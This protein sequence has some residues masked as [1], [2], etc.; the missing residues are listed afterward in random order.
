MS[1]SASPD[2]QD[3]SAAPGAPTPAAPEPLT[4]AASVS[5]ASKSGAEPH[6]GVGLAEGPKRSRPRF[7]F[8]GIVSAVTLLLDI[9][10]KAWAEVTLT[11]RP[12]HQPSITVIADH[13]SF[14]LAYNRG[15]AWGLLQDAH[16][17]IRL[18]FF[19]TV[20]IVAL[21]FITWLY[22]K[23]VRGQRALMWGLPLVMGGALGNFSDRITRSSV[24]DFI[25]YRAQWV[26]AMNRL[27]GKVSP[28]WTITDHWPT[29][30]VADIAICVGVGLIGLDMFTSKHGPVQQ[31]PGSPLQPGANRESSSSETAPSA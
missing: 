6:A 12:A 16:E 1:E 28:N 24:I 19:L 13:L 2:A 22:S 10:S 23:L 26:L 7:V 3:L 21:L 31:D 29:F 25:D 4:N 5:A 11:S 27:I 9:A 30:N 15:G 14:T 17:S 20:N 8:F 18:L